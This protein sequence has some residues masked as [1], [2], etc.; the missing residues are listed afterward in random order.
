ML[1]PSTISLATALALACSSA[2]AA[3][4]SPKYMARITPFQQQMIEKWTDPQQAPAAL[5]GTVSDARSEI[6]RMLTHVSCK[7]NYDPKVLTLP[8]SERTPYNDAGPMTELSAHQHRDSVCLTVD[9]IREWKRVGPDA[10]GFEVVY[11]SGDSLET[12][13]KRYEARKQQTNEWQLVYPQE[14]QTKR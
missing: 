6:Q 3:P 11:R 9:R 5:R 12:V 4:G 13:T 10:I 1:K 2:F 7:A 8:A 14:A